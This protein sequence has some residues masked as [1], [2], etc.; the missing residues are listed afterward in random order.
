MTNWHTIIYGRNKK[1]QRQV[2][3]KTV[4]GQIVWHFPKYFKLSLLRKFNQIGEGIKPAL[5]DT[6][7]HNS[8]SKLQQSFNGMWL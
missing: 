7:M 8:H 4:R 6:F 2:I 5:R 3:F 1:N